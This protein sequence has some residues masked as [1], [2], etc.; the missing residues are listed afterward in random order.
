MINGCDVIWVL[1]QWCGIGFVFQYY[2]VF[3]YLIV[4]DNVV[5]GLKICKCFKVEI[6][7]KVDNLLQVV[8]LSGF[9][10]CYFNQFF[11]G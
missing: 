8:G 5:F 10:S 4:C 9:Q 11:G 7:V 1:L 3:K 2:V 6:K